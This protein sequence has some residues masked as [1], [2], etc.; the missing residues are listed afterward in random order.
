[1]TTS[2]QITA[3]IC[4]TV[5]ILCWMGGEQDEGQSIAGLPGPYC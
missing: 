2:V 4:I 5:I 1:M 3:I